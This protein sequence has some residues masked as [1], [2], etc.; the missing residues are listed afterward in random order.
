MRVCSQKRE[1]GKDHMATLAVPWVR[2]H[3]APDNFD[4]REFSVTARQTL[5]LG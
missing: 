5:K 1:T 2:V 3:Q 4:E